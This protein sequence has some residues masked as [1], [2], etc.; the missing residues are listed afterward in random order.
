MAQANTPVVR[1][2]ALILNRFESLPVGSTGWWHWLETATV[3]S[4]APTWTYFRLT[5]RRERRRHQLY[6]YAYLKNDR[7]LHNAYLGKSAVLDLDRLDAVMR[8]LITRCRA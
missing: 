3:F 4:Y 7:K 6:W 2:T 8:R 1:G 5:A